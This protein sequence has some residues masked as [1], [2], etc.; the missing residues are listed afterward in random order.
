M[1]DRRFIVLAANPETQS[2]AQAGMDDGTADINGDFLE[3]QNPTSEAASEEDEYGSE[4]E[5]LP[6]HRP[7]RRYQ[8]ERVSL[9]LATLSTLSVL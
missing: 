2:F 8:D 5:N 6:V 4:F 7:S 1:T 3:A 9:M